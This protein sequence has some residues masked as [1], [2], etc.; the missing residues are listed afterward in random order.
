ME[1]I[2]LFNRYSKNPYTL[3][4]ENIDALIHYKD[5]QSI[6]VDFEKTLLRL[7]NY[8]SEKYFKEDYH[9]AANDLIIINPAQLVFN[10]YLK[11]I[12]LD[13]VITQNPNKIIVV[14][15]SQGD[16]EEKNLE[17]KSICH[18]SILASKIRAPF[19]IKLHGK[20]G[21]KQVANTKTTF[22]FLNLT[23][24]SGKQLLSEILTKIRVTKKNKFI[25]VAENHMKREI[26]SFLFYH[27]YSPINIDDAL[28]EFT[29]N[30]LKK[31][32]NFSLDIEDKKLLKKELKAILDKDITTSR[33]KDAYLIILEKIFEKAI[34][35]MIFQKSS[36]RDYILKLK[37]EEGISF[38]L[39]SAVKYPMALCL[40][41]ALKHN[42]ISIFCSEHGLTAGNSKDAI[43]SYY[44]NESNYS[45]AI[46][47]YN[48]ASYSTFSSNSLNKAKLIVAGAPRFTKK[49]PF[50]YI[51]KKLYK[52]KFKIKANE[53]VLYVSH[54]LERNYGKY[55]PFTKNNSEIYKDELKILEALSKQHRKVIYKP[56]HLTD[57]P[58]N[59]REY[60]K[61]H[62][63]RY[64]NISMLEVDEDFR[65][66]R[67]I[68][69]IIVT[70][71][72]EST[73][74]WCIGTG[75][76]LFFLDSNYYEP[77]ESREVVEKFN[78][79]FFVTNYDNFGWEQDFIKKIDR[80][81][82][83]IMNEWKIKT[84]RM[85]DLSE[86]NFLSCNKSPGS[87]GGNYILN[88]LKEVN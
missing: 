59:K 58:Y 48:N 80:P 67:S 61:K 32:N 20:N 29:S 44:I 82:V 2:E 7:N 35:F 43:K 75:V 4:R 40:Y 52:H 46:F 23:N 26:K 50:N 16:L 71:S 70:N 39:I 83:E 65:Y 69:D 8:F 86:E 64:P 18:Y 17:E 15:C 88:S 33:V 74:E 11:S 31:E 62:I 30:S 14:S 45:D 81:M 36:L 84:Q 79:V 34:A 27:G 19:E 10:Y 22:P 53:I 72:S 54:S 85:N 1:K 60:L 55:F 38:A 9:F 77:L 5:Y 24:F 6:F 73:L 3:D 78:Q 51:K 57:L 25:E 56:H 66:L 76:P 21:L 37:Q 13:K 47:L 28:G 68:A 12:I 41:D 42:N 63:E 49:I 87:I